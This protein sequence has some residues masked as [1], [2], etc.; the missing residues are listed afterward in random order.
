MCGGCIRGRLCEGSPEEIYEARALNIQTQGNA[1]LGKYDAFCFMFFFLMHF[2][3][4][5]C[6]F[7]WILM[8]FSK[9]NEMFLLF[10]GVEC[11]IMFL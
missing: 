7:R 1:G 11:V 10:F 8:L 5:C 9:G 4:L 2:F 6:F 3:C